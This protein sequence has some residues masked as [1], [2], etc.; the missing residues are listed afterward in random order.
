MARN[1][2]GRVLR[3]AAVGAALLSSCGGELRREAG[4]ME[5][6]ARDLFGD[7]HADI[8]EAPWQVS[9]QSS[10]G[11]H[12]CGG[13]VLGPS[14]VLTAQHCVDQAGFAIQSPAKLRIAAGSP[15]LSG[16][17]G[18]G[19]VRDVDDIFVFPHYVDAEQGR[20]VA[21]LHLATPLDLGGESVKAISLATPEDEAAGQLR[22]GVVSTMTGWGTLSSGRAPRDELQTVDV[23]LVSNDT[24]S[25]LYGQSITA[26]QLAAGG[27][28]RGGEDA[29][30]GDRGGP[31]VV[32]V[33]GAKVLAGVM[34]WGAG[35]ARARSPG[36]SAR[37]SSFQP[38]LAG[39]LGRSIV[40][41]SSSTGLSGAA[42]SFTHAAVTVPPGTPVL[43]VHLSGGTGDGDLYVRRGTQPTTTV[44]TCRP[45][46]GG[47]RESC[48]IPAPEAGTWYVSVRGYSD[49]AGV[50]LRVTTY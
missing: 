28:V 13:S 22:A 25:A 6:L 3:G 29:C 35:C 11:T 16:M 21:L 15:R 38:W 19:Q 18:D 50:S 43:N 23:P 5:W 41:L 36:M 10:E 24:A 33:G 45:N 8:R 48:S 14:W 37:V 9:L 20:D 30:Q 47:N 12:F 1:P 44:Y 42:G 7:A 39:I 4:G 34:S 17:D 31:L 46:A 40:T 32:S 2:M 27:P 26:D 49:Y